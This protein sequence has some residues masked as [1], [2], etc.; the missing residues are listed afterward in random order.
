MDSYVLAREDAIAK[1]REL[2]GPTKVFKA[3][4]SHPETIRGKYG[5]TD[6]RNATHGSGTSYTFLV[7]YAKQLSAPIHI[8]FFL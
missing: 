8:A 1:W 7:T 3:K 6:T 2:M 4:I 5:L